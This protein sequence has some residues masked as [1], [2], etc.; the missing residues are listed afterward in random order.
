VIRLEQPIREIAG[1]SMIGSIE[2]DVLTSFVGNHDVPR[3]MAEPGAT[4]AGLKLAEAF[5]MTTRGTP[6]LYYGDEFA[7][8]R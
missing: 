8:R 4:V 5:I 3:F 6:I 7:M 2:A 1:N